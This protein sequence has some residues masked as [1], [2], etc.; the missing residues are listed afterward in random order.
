MPTSPNQRIK[1]LY[2]KRILQERTD[3]DH[4]LTIRELLDAL[5]EYGIVAERKSIYSD[6]ES[7]RQYGLDVEMRKSKT[8]GYYIA[9][10]KFELPELK[11]LVDAVQ[12]SRFI[13]RKKSNELINKLSSLTSTYQATQL[14]RQVITADRPKAINESV[15]Y[16]I[17]A[18]HSAINTEKK[19]SFKYF[20][21]SLNKARSYRRA[22]ELYSHTPLA[23]CWND[24]KYYLIC[25]S[26]KYDSFVHYRVDRMSNVSVC[27]EQADKVDNNRFNVS[28][29]IKH[30]FSM[31]SGK[32]VSARLRFHSSLINTVLDRFGTD[33]SLD[34]NGDSFEISVKV[35]ESSA[36]LS[37]VAQFGKKAEILLPTNLRENMRSL[38]SE[39]NTIYE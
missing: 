1:L 24:D 39:L 16:N 22:G 10:R 28:E 13:T 34:I 29:H 7:L 4:T 36:F 11:L 6:L 12:S 25:Y 17:D 20:D 9:S 21:Y 3:D 30:V 32:V 5:A 2:L 37:W 23:L 31:Y 33:V 18:I 35:S 38:I 19:I 15:Y 14:R 27:A 26:A 8:F